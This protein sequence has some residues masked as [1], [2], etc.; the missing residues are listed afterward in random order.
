M[1]GT[2]AGGATDGPNDSLRGL[3][4]VA[5]WAIALSLAAV[6]LAVVAAAFALAPGWYKLGVVLLVPLLTPLESLLVTPLYTVAGRFRYYSPFLLSTG[7]EHTYDLHVGTLFDYVWN[8]RWSER[9]ARARGIV[10]AEMLRGLLVLCEE[11]ERGV[12]ARKATINATSYFF[13]DRSAARLGFTIEP[14]PRSQ[15][16]NL[17]LS[18]ASVA[19]RL[20]FTQG[21]PSWPDL[22]RIRRL[23]TTGAILLGHRPQVE[24]MLAR[25]ER[26]AA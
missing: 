15:V 1:R 2:R 13:S 22:R 3:S 8:L 9:G 7:T 21:R 25:T 19:L 16:L 23:T 11:I 4:G 5:R 14:A 24:R 20:S 6:Y 10:T 18:S 26:R 17:I 12:V